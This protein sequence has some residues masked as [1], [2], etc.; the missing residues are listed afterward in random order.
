MSAND[1]STELTSNK[2][3]AIQ[4]SFST[5]LVIEKGVEFST[6]CVTEL[7]LLH[8]AHHHWGCGFQQDETGCQIMIRPRS[9]QWRHCHHQPLQTQLLCH[10]HV[11]TSL[12]LQCDYRPSVLKGTAVPLPG[13]VLKGQLWD[14]AVPRKAGVARSQH[15]SRNISEIEA[16]AQATAWVW[17]QQSGC[18]IPAQTTSLR[19]IPLSLFF[20]VFMVG[21]GKR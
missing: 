7:F 13:L 20:V 17:A 6:P 16:A 19:G 14:T 9:L 2:K 18:T 8:Q 12:F 15:W 4:E 3:M 5:V 21:R 1:T 11:G 10:P